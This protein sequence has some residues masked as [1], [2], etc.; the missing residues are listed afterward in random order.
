MPYCTISGAN[1]YYETHGSGP[2][3]VFAHGAGGNH[4]SWYQQVPFFRDRHTCVIFDHRGFGRSLDAR[5]VEERPRFDEDL[6]ELIDQLG[7]ADVRLVAQSMGGWTC[8]GYAVTHPERVRA[9]V[10]ADTAGGLTSPELDAVRKEAQERRG[11]LPLLGGA[12]SQ[13][14]RERDPRGAFLYE[15]IFGLNPPREQALGGGTPMNRLSGSVEQSAA[16]RMPVLFIEG[17]NDLLIPPEVIRVAQA[18][19]P[20]ARLQMVAGSGHSVYFERPDEFKRCL[21]AFLGETDG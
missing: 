1:L 3:I 6:A 7:L 12:I 16:L 14:F 10:M 20:G 17:E 15:Q 13:G 8:L 21:D 19:I 11:N 4:L 18:I 5:S 9:L 2:A